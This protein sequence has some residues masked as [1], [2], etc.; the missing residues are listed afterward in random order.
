MFAR[1]LLRPFTA[2]ASV[3]TP[4]A[5]FFSVSP[6]TAHYFAR[7]QLPAPQFSAPAVVDGAFST[8]SLDDFKGKWLVLFSYPLDFTFVCPTEIIEFSER[9]S[10]FR[11]LGCEVVGFSVD[12][13]HSHLAW[14]NQPRKEGGLGGMNIPLVS[15]ITKQISADYGVLIEQ[16]GDIG[17]SLRG[18]FIIDPKQVVR[19]ISMND[20]GVGRSIDE[21]LRLVE[22]FQFND[23]HGDVCP[24]NWK[25]G[26][27]TMIADPTKS[28]EYFRAVN[29]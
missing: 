29:K 19:H 5:R 26:A 1:T 14:V 4:S 13:K 28:K 15:D 25:K 16:G 9:A 3:A 18:T 10:E 2:R 22:A 8:V 27:K 6:R 7:V 20:L 11:A 21:T 24:A 12:S 17:L 23:K